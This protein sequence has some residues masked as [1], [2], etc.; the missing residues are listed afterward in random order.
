MRLA[1]ALILAS[2]ALVLAACGGS[3]GV[4]RGDD[5]AA[6]K[7][8]F[9]QTP[10]RGETAFPSCSG[11]HTLK[12]AGSTATIGP[13]LDDAFRTPRREGFS[14]VTF[15]QVV[16]EQMEIPGVPPD[17][18]LNDPDGTPRIAMPSR[19]DYGLTSSEADNIAFYVATCAGNPDAGLDCPEIVPAAPAAAGPAE[20]DADAGG[21]ATGDDP[22]AQVF[23]QAGCGSCHVL[24]A[25]GASGMIGPSLDG[26]GLT[27]AA[28]TETVTNGR[29]AMPSFGD[30]LS[31]E[32]IQ[33]V[34]EFVAGAASG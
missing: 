12:D 23:A 11:C 34:A 7:E 10:S 14:P 5:I 32:Q 27:V 9:V 15:E 6:G 33:Q 2:L 8:L 26:S 29:G 22:G 16:R 31:E 19:D 4:S 18:A 30:Q 17:A 21:P 25:A 3:P 13:N 28:I 24:A 1:L 20:A